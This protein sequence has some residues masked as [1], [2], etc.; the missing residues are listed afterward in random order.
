MKYTTTTFVSGWRQVGGF[1]Q[2][3]RFLPQIKLTDTI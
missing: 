3:L 1:L 2:I